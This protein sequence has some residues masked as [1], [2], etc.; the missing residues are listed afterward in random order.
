[1]ASGAT[2]A[3]VERLTDEQE[4][5]GGHSPELGF[6]TAGTHAVTN[7][8]Y[9]EFGHIEEMRA[10]RRRLGLGEGAPTEMFSLRPSTFPL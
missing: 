2:L 4:L 3:L 10:I 6:V 1:M 7:V 9:H 8:V 5:R